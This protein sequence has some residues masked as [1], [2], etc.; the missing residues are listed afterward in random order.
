[1]G[2]ESETE[3]DAGNEKQRDKTQSCAALTS[4]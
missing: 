4:N 2:R 1:M 3:V